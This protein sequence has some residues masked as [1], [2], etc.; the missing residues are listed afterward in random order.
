[1]EEEG[2]PVDMATDPG[3]RNALRDELLAL[4]EATLNAKYLGF[5]T[6]D[7]DA[8][9]PDM[10]VITFEDGD[11]AD[12][13][14]RVIDRNEIVRIDETVRATLAADP[15]ALAKDVDQVGVPL[16]MGELDDGTVAII[17][18]EV[19]RAR[20]EIDARTPKGLWSWAQYDVDTRLP[21]VISPSGN[22][23][24]VPSELDAEELAA[25]INR[26]REESLDA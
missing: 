1:M 13:R 15:E 8:L 23:F 18:P 5:A 19:A 14:I 22:R 11:E 17:D 9:Q 24:P 25:E 6:V 2:E 12:I 21:V 3:L 7:R 20:E 10:L 26:G 4:V 16:R